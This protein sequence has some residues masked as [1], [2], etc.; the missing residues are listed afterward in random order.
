VS[1]SVLVPVLGALVVAAVFTAVL[2]SHLRARSARRRRRDA[3][4]SRQAAAAAERARLARDMHDSLSKTLDALALGAAALPTTL[5]EP[6]RARRLA[7]TLRDAS[8]HAAWESRQL[9]GEL[10]DAGS[11]LLD[12]DTVTTLGER[13]TRETGVPVT[14]TVDEVDVAEETAYELIWIL[15]EALRNIAAHAGAR[16]ATITLAPADDDGVSVTLTVTDDGRGFDVPPSLTPLQR[17]GHLG[18]VGMTERASICGG[19]LDVLSSAAG[20]RIVATVPASPASATESRPGRLIAF[21][22]VSALAVVATVVVLARHPAGP[23]SAPAPPAVSAGPVTSSAAVPSPSVGPS[24]S[25]RG[26][27][28]R[29]STARSASGTGTSPTPATRA[30]DVEYVLRTQWIPGFIADLHITNRTSSPLA[31]WTLRFGFPD[32][33]KLISSWSGIEATQSGRTVTITGTSEN[34]TIAAGAT[35]VISVQGTWTANDQPPD[36]FTMNGEPCG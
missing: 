4:A 12:R 31:P 27:G 16:H 13:W 1:R 11:G 7:Q 26:S 32:D 9:I 14:V 28:P 15:R 21:A 30:C 35:I 23:V 34:T 2:V 29:P 33:Q 17:A 19:R 5:D 24:A 36:A 8:V 6:G 20:T 22:A 18:L 3:V 25:A 10:R